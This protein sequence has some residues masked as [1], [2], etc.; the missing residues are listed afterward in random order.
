ML[1]LVFAG[2]EVSCRR[3]LGAADLFH[4]GERVDVDLAIADHLAEDLVAAADGLGRRRDGDIVMV[5][6]A[7]DSA[8]IDAIYQI[9]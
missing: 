7:G 2:G 4:R 8:G 1:G 5:S 3:Q 9:F 6:Q